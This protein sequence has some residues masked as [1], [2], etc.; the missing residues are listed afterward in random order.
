MLFGLIN[1]SYELRYTPDW[2]SLDTRPI[3]DWFDEAKIGIFVHW[4]TASVVAPRLPKSTEADTASC[5][6]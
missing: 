3:P 2:S 6:N 1:N 4:Y 5:N